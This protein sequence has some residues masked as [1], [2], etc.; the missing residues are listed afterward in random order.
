MALYV[1]AWHYVDNTEL[2]NRV[3]PEHRNYLRG[4]AD[5]GRLRAS[6]PFAD[7][8]GGVLVYHVADEEELIRLIEDDPFSRNN[9]IARYDAWE[10][11]PLIG[12]I[13]G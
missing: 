8:S 13:K 2:V 5:G 7:A 1:V 9:V 12:P 11:S 3:G 10:W 6:G 4:V